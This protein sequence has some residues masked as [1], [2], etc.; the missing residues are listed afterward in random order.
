MVGDSQEGAEAEQEQDGA[1]EQQQH[2]SDDKVFNFSAAAPSLSMGG[3]EDGLRARLP[4]RF[5]FR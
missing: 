5:K 1:K 4:S 2:P 3:W